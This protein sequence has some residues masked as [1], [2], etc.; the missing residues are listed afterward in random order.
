MGQK[1]EATTALVLQR[2][3]NSINGIQARDGAIEGGANEIN[4]CPCSACYIAKNA[5]YYIS[6]NSNELQ[7][8]QK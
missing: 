1:H 5:K 2:N 4:I 7:A 3:D 8:A 6:I